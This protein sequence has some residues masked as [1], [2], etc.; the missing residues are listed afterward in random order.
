[1][2][3]GREYVVECKGDG[4]VPS[5]LLQAYVGKKVKKCLNTGIMYKSIRAIIY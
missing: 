3:V 5:P 4:G 1:M 2:V